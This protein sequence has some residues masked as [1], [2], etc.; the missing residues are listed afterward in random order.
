MSSPTIHADDRLTSWEEAAFVAPGAHVVGDVQLGEDSS[1]WYGVVARGDV[2]RIRVGA[3]TNVQDNSVLHADPGHPCVLGEGVTV[4]HACIV[5]GARVEDHA[6]VG[7]GAVVMNGAVVGAESLVA[8]GA[9]VP[10]GMQIPPRSLVMG[11]PAKVRR[12]L[13]PE[14]V[15]GLHASAERYVLNARAHHAAG[16]DQRP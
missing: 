16:R 1:L 9:L 15:E 3:R 8:A 6:L 10:E 11:M 7:M 5:H 12:E 4:G 13:T 2:E 14:E